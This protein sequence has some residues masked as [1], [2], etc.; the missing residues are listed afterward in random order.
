MILCIAFCNCCVVYLNKQKFSVLDPSL[1]Q[2]IYL[3]RQDHFSAV[4]CWPLAIVRHIRN[5]QPQRIKFKSIT[6]RSEYKSDHQV[7]LTMRLQNGSGTTCSFFTLSLYL[8][9]KS[10][11]LKLRK[12]GVLRN[13]QDL[14]MGRGTAIFKIVASQ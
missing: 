5:C 6:A 1:T 8:C 4:L 2:K 10:S 11:K 14:M 7:L 3:V 12:L 9:L 13:P